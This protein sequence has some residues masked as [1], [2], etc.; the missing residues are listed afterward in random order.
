MK[1]Q[2]TT[3]IAASAPGMTIRFVTS[4]EF[5]AF[6]REYRDLIEKHQALLRAKYGEW[7]ASEDCYVKDEQTG[8]QEDG[9]VKPDRQ[10]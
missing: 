6:D 5:L 2:A 9:A 3:R 1:T 7:C 8:G 4:Q 10:S